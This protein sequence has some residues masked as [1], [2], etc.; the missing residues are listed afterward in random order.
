MNELHAITGPCKAKSSCL[1]RKLS[2]NV[3]KF[4]VVTDIQH[5]VE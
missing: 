5:I 2:H 1:L 4:V 3:D